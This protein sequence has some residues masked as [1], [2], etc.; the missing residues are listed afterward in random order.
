M[1]FS[2]HS[3][4]FEIITKSITAEDCALLADPVTP[5]EIRQAM[6]SILGNKAPGLDGFNS[7]FF[8]HTWEVIG[9]LV[10]QAIQNFFNTGQL[11]K[12]INT[13]I[14]T[15]IL[16]IPNAFRMGEFL[17]IACC[18]TIYKYISKVLSLRIK[19]VL[20]TLVDESQSAFVHG[21]RIRDNFY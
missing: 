10:V 8:K 5:E 15:L 11:V 12:E 4:L 3:L 7:F 18:N 2:R 13:T 20:P 14:I 21:R 17:P 1:N 16:K 6:F 19:Q 9:G